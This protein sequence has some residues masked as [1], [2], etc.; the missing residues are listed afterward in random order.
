[1][2]IRP[3]VLQFGVNSAHQRLSD[4][5]NGPQ[6]DPKTTI[7][8]V[9]EGPGTASSHENW[10]APVMMDLHRANAALLSTPSFLTP[11]AALAGE[12]HATR[13]HSQI[14]CFGTEH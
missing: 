4:T 2:P 11:E 5:L 10:S 1:M 12:K 14:W 8:H 13:N 9:S 6:S 7:G 3:W